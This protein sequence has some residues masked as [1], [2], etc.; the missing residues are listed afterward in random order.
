MEGERQARAFQRYDR[1]QGGGSQ[2]VGADRRKGDMP[3]RDDERRDDRNFGSDR[4]H[5]ERFAARKLKPVREEVGR[6]PV[7]AVRRKDRLLVDVDWRD[8][9]LR[10]RCS[11]RPG[12][13]QHTCPVIR[14]TAI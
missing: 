5:G 6:A 1:G 9:R 3:R 4:G 12:R 14:V 8:C 7:P 10:H 13:A 2:P 11:S